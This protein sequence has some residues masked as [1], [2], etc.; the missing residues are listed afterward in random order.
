ML[1]VASDPTRDTLIQLVANGNGLAVK[2]GGAINIEAGG[3]IQFGGVDLTATIAALANNA[4]RY[5]AAGSAKSLTSANDKQTIELNALAGSIVTLP[6]ATGSGVKYRFVVTVLPTSNSHVVQVASASDFMVGSVEA[7]LASGVIDGFSAANSGTVATNSDTI[8]LNRST[9][10][11]VHLGEYFSLEDLAANTWLV[12]ES[13]LTE[14]STGATPF[15][16]AV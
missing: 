10:G 4:A 13:L 7:V 15:S 2:S 14:T 11:G 9:T 16:A 8:T 6:A 5:V 1:N 3:G 12:S